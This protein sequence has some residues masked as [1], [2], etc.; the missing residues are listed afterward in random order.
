MRDFIKIITEAQLQ[1]EIIDDDGDV[2]HAKYASFDDDGEAYIRYWATRE[3]EIV[4]QSMHSSPTV[5]GRDMLKWLNDTYNLPIAVVD[6]TFEADGFWARM[7]REGLVHS[8]D[9]ADGWPSPKEAKSA[10]LDGVLDGSAIRY[11]D[12][13]DDDL[14]EGCSCCGS[15]VIDEAAG[16]ADTLDHLIAKYKEFNRLYFGNRLPLMPIGWGRMKNSGA[17]V[18]YSAIKR[19][20]IRYPM[21]ETMRVVFSTKYKRDAAALEPLLLHEM[22]HVY[23]LAIEQDA[24]DNHGPKFLDI[25]AR[26][27]RES[28]VDIPLTDDTKGLELTDATAKPVGVLLRRFQSGGSTKAVYAMFSANVLR[29]KLDALPGMFTRRFHEKVEARIVTSSIWWE[30]SQRS[31]VQRTLSYKTDY[32]ILKPDE[33]ADLLANSE[34]IW[35]N[36]GSDEL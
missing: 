26:L 30:K 17:A 34:V 12:L 36:G 24:E 4:I 35:T 1:P 5:R 19:G 11:D 14:H 33:L 15:D 2:A 28:G 7:E 16:D 25:L 13:E 20:G 3:G 10:P 23:L 9:A 6:A 32:F 21:V 8:V 18:V 29:N 31:R 27:R 22:I